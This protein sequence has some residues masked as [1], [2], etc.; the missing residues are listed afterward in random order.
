MYNSVTLQ[1]LICVCVTYNYSPFVK[2]RKT[3]IDVEGKHQRQLRT[4]LGRVTYVFVKLGLLYSVHIHINIV[5]SASLKIHL[6]PSLLGI[7]NTI[8]VFNVFVE[9]ENIHEG[10]VY[11]ASCY[12]EHIRFSLINLY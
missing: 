4:A 12:S 8:A 6:L 9:F 1:A 5:K 10:I 3:L 7:Y 2:L 11:R